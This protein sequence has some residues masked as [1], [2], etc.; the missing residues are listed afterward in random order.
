[1]YARFLEMLIQHLAPHLTIKGVRYLYYSGNDIQNDWLRSMLLTQGFLPYRMLYA[2]D[3]FDY[4]IPSLGNMQVTVRPVQ[5][6]DI[7]ALL[8]IEEAC[9]EDLWRY[10]TVAFQD[11]A[12]SHPYFVVAE[13]AGK[14]VGYQF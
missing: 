4:R 2:Y 8:A 10:D 7:P 13:L 1:A 11:I 9:F 6:S 14:V 12:A 5:V 3:K